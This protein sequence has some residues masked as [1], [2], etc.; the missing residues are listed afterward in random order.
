MYVY[1]Y[2]YTHVYIYIYTYDYYIICTRANLA[3]RL[4]GDCPRLFPPVS[5][6]TR[7]QPAMCDVAVFGI[8]IGSWPLTNTYS[9][10]AV[11]SLTDAHRPK[12]MTRNI[13]ESC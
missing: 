9:Y 6:F 11:S 1:I 7:T 12:T 3:K 2:I 4:N 10:A 13:H 8:L 5:T